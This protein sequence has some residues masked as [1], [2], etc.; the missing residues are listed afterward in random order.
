MDHRKCAPPPRAFVDEPFR[1]CFASHL[2]KSLVFAAGSS[3]CV[4]GKRGYC[5]NAKG[6]YYIKTYA[7]AADCTGAETKGTEIALPGFSN[8]D[9]ERDTHGI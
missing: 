8:A 2:T 9:G 5:D 1:Y 3:A 4:A 7:G 6:T